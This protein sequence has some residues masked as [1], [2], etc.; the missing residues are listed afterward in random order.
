VSDDEL[1]DVHEEGMVDA[2]EA[3][4]EMAA[5]AGAHHASTGVKP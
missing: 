4:R 5:Q 1:I 3:E 2:M